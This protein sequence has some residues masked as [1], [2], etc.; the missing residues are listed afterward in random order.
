MLVR[1]LSLGMGAVF[2]SGLM[3]STLLPP[4]KAPDLDYSKVILSHQYHADI[5]HPDAFL[6]V[7]LGQRV[8]SPAQIT[9]AV[10]AWA[11]QSDRVELI[12]YAQSHEGR[13]LHAVFVS[14]PELLAQ[15]DAILEKLAKLADP[16]A[17]SDAEAESIIA[18]LPA[19]AWMAYSIHG[20]ETSGA[21]AAMALIYHLAASQDETVESLLSNMIV[22]IDP[23]MNPDGRDRFSKSLEQYRG[24]APNVDDQ[25]LLHRGDWPSGRTNHYFFDL[26][27]DFFYLTQP[28]TRGRVALINKWRPQLMIDGHE[29]GPQD[30]YLFGPAREPKNKN[31]APS[32]Q[33]WAQ[34][35]SEDQGSAFDQHA[36]RYYTGEWFENLY[37]GYSNYAEYRGAT[38]ILYE[39]SRMA[40]DGVRRP[41]GTVQTYQ[42]SVHHQFVSSIA[43]LATLA[44]HSQA[45]YQDYWQDRKFVVSSKSPYAKRSYVILPTNNH[46]RLQ[47][48]VEKLRA[49]DIEVLVNT[50]TIDVKQARNHLG[51]MQS[52]TLPIGS[53]II[54][55]RQ[56][57]ARLL[58]AIME[59]DAKLLPEVMELEREKVLRD[60]SSIMYDTTAWNLSMMYGLEALTVEQE[61]TRNTTVFEGISVN[62][63]Q[64]DDKA[65]A[66]SIDGSSDHAV[67]FAAR[68]MEQGVFVR[69][70]DKATQLGEV[71]LAR[72]AIIVTK[73]DNPSLTGL[74]NILSATANELSLSVDNIYTGYGKGDAPEWGGE[75]FV[76]LS[77]PQLAIASQSP[78]SS[79]DLGATWYAVDS[80]LGI[81]HSQLDIGSISRA[82][83]RRYNVIVL[84]H[85]WGT[86]PKASLSA[87]ADWVSQGGTLIT[88]QS[89]SAQ[90]IKHGELTKVKLI[91][92][93]AEHAEDFNIAL[94]RR[95][96]AQKSFSNFAQLEQHHLVTSLDYPWDFSAKA[97]N[98]DELKRLESWQK[99]FMPSGAMLA[100]QVDQQ[101]WLSFGVSE[102]L[103]VLFSDMP[104]M[105]APQS[106][107]SVVSIGVYTDLDEDKSL[108]L[109]KNIAWYSLPSNQQLNVR[110]SG[111]LWPEAAQRVANASY[112]TRERVGMGQVIMFAGQPNFRG[113]SLGTNRLLLNAI[114]YGPG[115]GTRP[116]IS[117]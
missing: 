67:S 100:T 40:E 115:M 58:A 113:A 87:L 44:E 97:L 60:G 70:I 101:H 104:V 38:H 94:Q 47:T 49:Q 20:N 82:D 64:L 18:S 21:D 92:D 102:Q 34:V 71:K 30:T 35:F 91:E 16:R 84:P 37:P 15:R 23:M 83:L 103:P 39:Q 96:L 46:A 26:N 75:H 85:A 57:E 66:W 24:T 33:K 116:Q 29:M 81:R 12:D 108:E 63:K 78:M 56:P 19:I 99:L 4:T 25:S 17:T 80:H 89:S 73:T 41:E 86:L 90:L 2:A 50:K 76:L 114:V 77:R 110:M 112:L 31:I 117:L 42:E 10:R 13:P 1:I 51:Q 8:A 6:D 109:E 55:N 5:T 14:S 98:K 68:L 28:E 107:E 22:V 106:A 61:I 45:M 3:A 62:Q 74:S 105:L 95:L 11:K 111:L 36:W 32:V 53:L 52:V 54:N 93:I 72:G 69:A 88:H 7:P 59:F 48:L 9:R 43:N 79:Y 27:R 65:I